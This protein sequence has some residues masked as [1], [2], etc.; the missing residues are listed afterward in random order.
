MLGGRVELGKSLAHHVPEE[1]THVL[2]EIRPLTSVSTGN[3]VHHLREEPVHLLLPAGPRLLRNVAPR[4]APQQIAH[5]RLSL[6]FLS[7]SVLA[8]QAVERLEEKVPH[9]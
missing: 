1:S 7:A 9:A 2:S 8:H 4:Y 6:S 5:A 3:V